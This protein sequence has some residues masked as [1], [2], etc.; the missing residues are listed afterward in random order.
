MIDV[1]SYRAIIL[2]NISKYIQFTNEYI[3][4]KSLIIGYKIKT[5]DGYKFMPVFNHK[6][7]I[8]RNNLNSEFHQNYNERIKNI[9]I[10]CLYWNIGLP[11]ELCHKITFYM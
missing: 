1:F 11:L 5:I 9:T 2:G 4:S 6:L 3:I 8:I 7:G 10:G